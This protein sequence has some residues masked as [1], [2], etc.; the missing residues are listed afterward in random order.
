M[1]PHEYVLKDFITI[2]KTLFYLKCVKFQGTI[3][4]LLICSFDGLEKNYFHDMTR[5][6]IFQE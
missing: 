3:I 1:S 2:Y 5:L 6:N 4:I